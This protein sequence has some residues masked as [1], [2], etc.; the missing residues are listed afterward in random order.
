MS[1]VAG[2]ASAR[3]VL[4]QQACAGQ[5]DSKPLTFQD[6]YVAKQSIFIAGVAIG[7]DEAQNILCLFAFRLV[8]P[9]Q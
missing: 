4:S 3:G 9:R 1:I 8:Y 7:F 2:A 6:V 5:R